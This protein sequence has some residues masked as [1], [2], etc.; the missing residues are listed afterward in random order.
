MD[1]SKILQADPK[2]I[3][4]HIIGICGVATGAVAVAFKNKGYIV[5]G[6]DKGFWPP[7]S[8]ELEKHSV[9]FYAG[10][11]PERMSIIRPDGT[12][13]LPDLVIA[14]T[15]S[16]SSNPETLFAESQG[17]PI[18]SFA[19]AIGL[20]FARKNSL[21]CVGTWGKTS[22]SA[23]LSHIF[24]HADFDPTY[25]FGGLSLSHEQSAYI[26]NSEWSI[27]EG[28]E[29]KSS[30]T[31]TSPKFAY[32]KPTHCILT[33]VAWDHADLYPTPEDFKNV[34]VKLL[35][36]IPRS[37]FVVA[38]ID[39]EGVRDV[40]SHAPEVK[41]ITYGSADTDW[42]PDYSYSEITED[43]HGL[44]CIISHGD[45]DYKI[46]SPMLGS[47]QV[48]N[49]TACFAMAHMHGI[50]PEKIIEAIKSFKGMKRRLERRLDAHD[51]KLGITVIDDIAHSADKARTTLETLRRIYDGKITA[52]FEPNIGGRMPE[53]LKKYAHAFNSADKVI[54]PRLTKLKVSDDIH[55]PVPVDGEK[56]H[57]TISETHNNALYIDDDDNLISEITKTPHKGDVIVFLGSHGF[58]KMIE[59]TV[60]TF[61][62]Q[63]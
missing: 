20:L 26:G 45:T 2:T 5:T 50:S 3:H 14:G 13:R 48:E 60:S 57:A 43:I 19:Q 62:H 10:W 59:T 34:F 42:N 32:Y 35:H 30:P 56:L 39:N 27:F 7:V 15:A 44:T 22:N 9:N 18:V 38:C 54:I 52:I 23:L 53:A 47:Y 51:T 49:I 58:R 40:L 17:I 25:M 36:N 11:H 8:T 31:D 28:D 21:V 29:Y 37:G 33:A 63:Q 24:M 55:A 41:V 6:S 61:L 46:S 1:I 16:G 12:H 4:I